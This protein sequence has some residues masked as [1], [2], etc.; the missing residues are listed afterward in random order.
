M[1]IQA[2]PREAHPDIGQRVTLLRGQ[3]RESEERLECQSEEEDPRDAAERHADPQGGPHHDEERM[4]D[5]LSVSD[6]SRCP[7]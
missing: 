6:S 5:P 1:N 7:V 2:Q 4:P 3:V